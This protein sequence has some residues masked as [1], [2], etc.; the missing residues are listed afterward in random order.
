MATSPTDFKLTLLPASEKLYTTSYIA[1]SLD[2]AHCKLITANR[3]LPYH[4]YRITEQQ[5]AIFPK[6]AEKRIINHIN[7]GAMSKGL[8]AKQ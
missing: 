8:Y 1:A 7:Y 4:K 5:L 6:A 2:T 3:L